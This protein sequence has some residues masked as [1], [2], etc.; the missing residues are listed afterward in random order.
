M[1]MAKVLGRRPVKIQRREKY[2]IVR[3]KTKDFV[4]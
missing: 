4:L 1:K 3:Y 2:Y